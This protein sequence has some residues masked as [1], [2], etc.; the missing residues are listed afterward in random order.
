MKQDIDNEKKERETRGVEY[1]HNIY[2]KSSKSR[3][4]YNTRD[5]II[6]DYDI[7]KK[8]INYILENKND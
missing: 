3:I 4:D 6:E 5:G 1:S 8:L 2:F 7:P